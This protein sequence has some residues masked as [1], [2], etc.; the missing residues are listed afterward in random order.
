MLPS[1]SK[2]NVVD[3]DKY[4]RGWRMEFYSQKT[5]CPGGKRTMAL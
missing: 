2:T 4:G 1:W 5:V 3:Y